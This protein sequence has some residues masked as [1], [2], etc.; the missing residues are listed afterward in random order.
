[1]NRFADLGCG[2]YHYIPFCI[3]MSL[4]KHPVLLSHFEK[5]YTEL[6]V[7]VVALFFM[8]YLKLPSWHGFSL[9]TLSTLFLSSV[10]SIAVFVLLKNTSCSRLSGLAK[11]G[12]YSIQIYIIHYVFLLTCY[13]IG[14]FWVQSTFSTCLL[15]ELL[16]ALPLAIVIIC[17]S[18]GVAKIMQKS[19]FLSK[20]C[21]GQF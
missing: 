20:L 8:Q 5:R 13:P 19:L 4:S 18:I 9:A 16:Y 14:E 17:L 12:R 1:M 7:A 6:F 21:F 10:C 2:I 3:G 15:T 11:I